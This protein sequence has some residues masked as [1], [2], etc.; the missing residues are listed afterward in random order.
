M[1]WSRLLAAMVPKRKPV[2]ALAVLKN[3]GRDESEKGNAEIGPVSYDALE[4][5][6]EDVGGSGHPCHCAQREEGPD[7]V[8]VG[9][10]DSNLPAKSSQPQQQ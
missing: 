5:P 6:L 9:H 10:G 3:L 2:F 7:E 1:T 8:D 4:I